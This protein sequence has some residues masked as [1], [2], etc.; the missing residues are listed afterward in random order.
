MSVRQSSAPPAARRNDTWAAI[1]LIGILLGVMGGIGHAY[2]TGSHPHPEGL[3][4][5]TLG[6]AVATLWV[7]ARLFGP[8]R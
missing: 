6:T 2:Y 7:I 8:R 5:A 3:F 1:G 4:V